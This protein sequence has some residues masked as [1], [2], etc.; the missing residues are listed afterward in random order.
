MIKILFF[1]DSISGGGAEKVL[2]NLVNNMDQSKFEITV[3][4]INDPVNAAELLK[5]GIRYKTINRFKNRFLNRIYQYWI[6]LCAELKILYPLYIKDDYDIEVAYLECGPTKIIA[7][8]T[9]K[10]AAKIAW[11]HCDLEKKEGFADSV[12]KSRKY[13][14][15]FDRIVCVSQNVMQSFEK[16][17][18]MQTKAV[19]LYNVND[20]K[21]ILEKAEEC[22]KI[23][24]DDKKILM[25]TIGRL[26]REK[27]VDRAVSVCNYLKTQGYNFELWILGEGKERQNLERIIKENNLSEYVKLMGFVSNPY[28]YIKMADII[29]CPSRYEGLSTVITEG[30]VLGKAIVT[31]DCSGMRELLGKSEYGIITDNS[32][33]G[34]YNGIKQLMDN[35]VA[36]ENISEKAKQRGNVLSKAKTVAFIEGFFEK[37]IQKNMS[38]E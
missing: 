16:F 21:E 2:R 8:S 32:E 6:R 37:I 12:E 27:G 33:E 24:R 5:A 7:S 29:V 36:I 28:P 15:K 26:S 1:I 35:P 18:G 38:G 14:Q 3:Q 10:K 25:E 30:L 9:N 19:V 22:I 23:K 34:L 13:Y 4:T 11:V 31:T 17:F 20:E